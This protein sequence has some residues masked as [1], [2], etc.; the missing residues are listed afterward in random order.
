MRPDIAI[1]IGDD[2]NAG[3]NSSPSSFLF[4]PSLSPF[5]VSLFKDVS[6]H[7]HP[8]YPEPGFVSGFVLDRWS[9]G[10]LSWQGFLCALQKIVRIFPSVIPSTKPSVFALP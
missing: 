3:R 8:T 2:G 5:L 7:H 4:L 6:T 10:Q 9:D 1:V